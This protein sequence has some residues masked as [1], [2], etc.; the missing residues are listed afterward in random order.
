MK[1][2]SIAVLCL[3]LSLFADSQ[4]EFTIHG[5][6][7]R[8]LKSKSVILGSSYGTFTGEIKDDGSF[9]ITGNGIKTPGDALI[10]TDSSNA[11][12]IWLEPGEYYIECRE[13]KL[14]IT[15]KPIFRIPKLTGPK[16]AEIKHRY[17]EQFFEFNS[18]P[19][20][21]R[22]QVAKDF[23]IRYID[24]VF[25]NYP[26]SNVL[27]N[28]VRSS[29][30]LLGDEAVKTY[31]S[32]LSD[33]QKSQ[34]GGEQLAYYFKRK[35]KVEKEIYFQDFEMKDQNGKAFRL[36]SVKKKLI[37]L[38]FW[39]SDCASCRRKHPK[40]AD[41][42]RKYA[43]KGFEIVSISFDD[44]KEDWIK[45]II[46]DKMSWVNVSELKGWETSI[47]ETYFIKSLPF[48]IWLDKDKKIISL[49]DLSE[50]EIVEYLK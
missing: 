44:T 31:F 39:S 26:A 20:A 45:A 11:N 2:I 37:L 29:T 27:P 34:P 46:K 41:L 42:Y 6:V 50:K 3:C 14:D 43:T 7:D 22:K 4:M 30:S 23:V 49:E 16:D 38:D 19:P 9:L 28:L 13:V 10:Y 17:Q 12:A 1:N 25:K 8:A 5:K 40:L 36:S 48:A 21:E 24:S 32:L 35:E 47:S 15:P 18:I 33:E